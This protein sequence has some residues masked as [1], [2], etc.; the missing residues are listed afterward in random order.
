MRVVSA[1]VSAQPCKP[2]KAPESKSPLEA[3]LAGI[4]FRPMQGR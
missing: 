4:G 2:E 3:G 1:P